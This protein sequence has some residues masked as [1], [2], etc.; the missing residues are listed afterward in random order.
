MSGD[1]KVFSVPLERGEGLVAAIEADPRSNTEIIRTALWNEFGGEKQ[2]AL[3]AQRT[4]KQAT[5]DK[6]RNEIAELNSRIEEYD[7]EI[8]TL[9]EKIG[10]LDTDGLPD[11]ADTDLDAVL[12]DMVEHD[13]K[14]Y[15]ASHGR[16][17]Q[18]AAEFSSEAAVVRDELQRRAVIQDRP[19]PAEQFYSLGDMEYARTGSHP[20]DYSPSLELE[21][22]KRI[23]DAPPADEID[24]DEMDDWEA[25]S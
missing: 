15:P 22:A 7:R 5:R 8:A 1:K 3:E 2:S 11:S 19:I 25:W 9:D 20:P 24:V 4:Q 17:Q 13:T 10:T 12:T 6:L 23:L 18:I 21:T 16:L 14:H